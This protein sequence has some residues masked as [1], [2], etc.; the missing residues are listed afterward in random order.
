MV[1]GNLLQFYKSQ[2]QEAILPFWLRALDDERGGVYTCYNN[3]G[4]AKVSTDKY[5]W[6][7]GRFIWILARLA[8]LCRQNMLAG[9]DGS[10]MAHAGKAVDFLRKYAFLPNGNCAFVLTEDGQKKEVVSGQGYD[11]SFYADC[12]VVLGFTEYANVA[13]DEAAL[14][15][16]LAL[17]DRIE[18]RLSAG[19]VRSEPYPVPP[20]YVNQA[21]SMIMLNVAQELAEAL[22][23]F[24]HARYGQILEQSSFYLK[25]IM[26]RFYRDDDTIQ[27]M[28]PIAGPIPDTILCN[29]VNPGHTIEC[30]WFVATS[31][32]RLKQPQYIEKAARAVKQAFTLGW[33]SEFGGLL[34]FVQRDGG[35]K[36]QGEISGD[37]FEKLIIDTWDTKLWWP[38]SEVLYTSLLFNKLTGDEAFQRIYDQAHEY[39]FNTFPQAE[40]AIGEWIQIR[41]R[42]GRPVDKL[43]A[44][45]VKDPYHILRNML[46]IIELLECEK[47]RS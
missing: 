16:A 23:S 31:A 40:Q 15:E 20:G 13:R 33:D 11:T 37:V 25:Q 1:S 6:S 26:E 18:Q 7:Q 36:P 3:F 29:H 27:E 19:N 14:N 39:V 46:L 34:R 28:M 32:M 47:S 41:D 21:F 9:D 17:Y 35:G 43:V 8:R 5:T 30:M 22:K 12:F 42:R 24:G 4:T 10:Y 2:V 44:L 45:P 38:H